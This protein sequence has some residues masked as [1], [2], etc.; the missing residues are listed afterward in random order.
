LCCFL[1]DFFVFFVVSS[2]SF[3]Y[4]VLFLTWLFW[5]VCC[6]LLDFFGLC[7]V[8]YLTCLAFVCCFLLDLFGK[9]VKEK[10]T[11]KPNKTRKKQ[12]KSQTSQ[13]RHNTKTKQVKEETTHNPNKSSKKQHTIQISQ[14][15]NNTQSK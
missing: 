1:L 11:H 8:S 2:F 5:I 13:V 4:C 9:Q 7:V 12:H 6:F 15:R 10:T 3:F 14:V